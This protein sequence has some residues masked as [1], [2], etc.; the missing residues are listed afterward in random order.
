MDSGHNAQDNALVGVIVGSHGTHGETKIQSHSDNPRR[1]LS[2]NTLISNGETLTIE[3]S[4]QH[5][6]HII[7]KFEGVN[8]MNH[9]KTLI[10][11]SLEI[12]IR[13]ISRLEPDNYYYYEIIGL[14]VWTSDSRYI[15]TVAEILSTGSNDVYIARDTEKDTM[16]PALKPVIKIVN[17]EHGYM[18]VELPDGL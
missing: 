13:F 18:V 10:G 11:R 6:G 3:T 5:K 14:N 9:A 7:V 4:R 17:L 8:S 1:F 12:P 16:I 2:G 15:G